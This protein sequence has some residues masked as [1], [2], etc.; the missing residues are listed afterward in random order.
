[1]ENKVIIT[2]REDGYRIEGI[3]TKPQMIM[4][5]A[6]ILATALFIATSNEERDKIGEEFISHLTERFRSFESGESDD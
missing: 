3:I 1:M 4:V 6:D 5:S 2:F